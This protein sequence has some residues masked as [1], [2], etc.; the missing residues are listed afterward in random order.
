[1][2][3]VL[4]HP[5]FD[6]LQYREA[7]CAALADLALVHTQ[8]HIAR[9][10]AAIPEQGLWNLD[11]DTVVSP[12]SKAAALRAAGAVCAAVDA[13]LTGEASTA[14][15][16]VRPPGHH[17]DAD[18]A[19]GFCLFNNIAV[20][21]MRARTRHHLARVAI[22]DFDL[23]HGNGTEKLFWN[24]P[25]VLFASLHQWPFDPGTGAETDTGAHHN[26]LNMPMSAG[27]GSA[28][29][30]AAVVTKL[31]PRLRWFAPELLLVSAGFDGHKADPLGSL[32]LDETDY[33][34]IAQQL[35]DVA[36]Q[37]CGGRVVAALE[38]GYDLAAL[39]ASAA[40]FVRAL[41][42]G[43]ATKPGAMPHAG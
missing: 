29:F 20:G 3:A 36:R 1:V 23:H 39:G 11:P 8:G 42:D 37:C 40:S 4:Q 2:L 18:H 19:A 9:T 5:E 12:G 24:E 14:F 43:A 26:V 27:D 25:G 22:I 41:V 38:G 30:R 31:L 28:E 32:A 7:P 33:S 15:C 13:V 10:L 34:W 16:A 6:P 17:A 21:A 35:L